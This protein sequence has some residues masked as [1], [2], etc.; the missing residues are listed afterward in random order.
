MEPEPEL[1]LE[2]L[3][4]VRKIHRE[5]NRWLNI[6]GVGVCLLGLAAMINAVDDWKDSRDL[7]DRI[8]ALNT[9]NECRYD[10]GQRVAELQGEISLELALGLAAFAD[11][12]GRSGELRVHTDRINELAPDLSDALKDRSRASQICGGN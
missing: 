4:Q 2:K 7:N 6:I 12:G 5:S 1:D 10:I 9:A 11:Q 8:Q 3:Q